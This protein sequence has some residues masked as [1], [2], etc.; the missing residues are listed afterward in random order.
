VLPYEP[1]TVVLYAG[2]NDL[3][4]GKSPEQV[5]NDFKAFVAKIHAKL[6]R[7]RV[8]YVSI[9]PSTKRWALIEKIKEANRLVKEFTQSDS[10]L[11]YVDIFTPMLGSDGNPRPELL[12][13]D[14][15]HLTREGYKL[16]AS[17]IRP[18]LN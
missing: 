18:V 9:K 14:G 6:P 15:L 5:L 13:A 8:A 1:K 16:W 10:R 12:A 4:A 2:D 11:V 3:A 17:V 7:T